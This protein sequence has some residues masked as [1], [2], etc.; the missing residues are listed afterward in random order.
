MLLLGGVKA[1]S[2][3]RWVFQ[4][5][6]QDIG[7][8]ASEASSW[9]AIAQDGP[10]TAAVLVG[11]LQNCWPARYNSGMPSGEEQGQGYTWPPPWATN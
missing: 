7:H 5:K 10:G 6:F 8:N 11:T 3:S 1:R 9:C 4:A 2:F